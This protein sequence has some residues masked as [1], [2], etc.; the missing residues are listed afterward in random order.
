MS[1]LMRD[2]KIVS[3]AKVFQEFVLVN[4]VS[5]YDEESSLQISPLSR[6]WKVRGKRKTS[7]K[8]SIRKIPILGQFR[9]LSLLTKSGPL[10]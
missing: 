6:F 10:F 4:F 2:I 3:Y 1:K 8:S 9:S 7:N 5:Y